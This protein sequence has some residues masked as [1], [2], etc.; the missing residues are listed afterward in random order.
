MF[1]IRSVLVIATFRDGL[2]YLFYEGCCM[3][4]QTHLF[5]AHNQLG[6]LMVD[7]AGW[8]MP[9][10][11]GSQIEEHRSVREHAGIFDVSHMSIVDV[12]GTGAKDFLSH[13]LA[14]NV[15]KLNEPGRALYGCMLNPEGGIIDDLI[16]YFISPTQ[17]KVVVNAAT[18]E[19]DL[20][21]FQKQASDFDVQIQ[22]REDLSLLAIQGP[23]AREIAAHALGGDVAAIIASLKPFRCETCQDWVIARTGY[24]GEDGIEIMLPHEDALKCWNQMIAAG[25]LPIGLGA[26]DTLRLEAGLNLYGTDMDEATTPYESNLGWTV[27]MEPETREFIGRTALRE[28]A[29]G[30]TDYKLVGLVMHKKGVLRS[31][32]DV[33]QAGEKVGQITSGTFSPTL[34]KS[35]AFARIKTPIADQYMVDI[36]GK[37]HQVSVVHTPFVKNGK[38]NI[39]LELDEE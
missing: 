29:Q 30:T 36:R 4:K 8:K 12:T 15:D 26:R 16:T 1:Q 9:L 21:W 18:T 14:N 25:V 38:P 5:S 11:Y 32:L 2:T 7:F 19:K 13:L 17:Y 10:H 22:R 24:T 3:A 34:K 35:I 39:A 33:F 28:Q 27:A 20:A 6:A 23:Q 31:G 37:Q